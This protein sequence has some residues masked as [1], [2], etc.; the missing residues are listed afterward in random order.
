MTTTTNSPSEVPLRLDGLTCR[1]GGR[2]VLDRVSMTVPAGSVL[3]LLGKNGTGKTTLLGCALG[4]VRPDAGSALV[5]GEPAAGL[6]A[7]AKARLG[8]VP[9]EVA[10]YPWMTAGQM[11][12]YT[13]AFYPRWSGPLVRR[14]LADWDVRPSDRI[15]RMSL[16]TRQKLAIIQQLAHEPDLLVLD[17]PAASLD[18]AARRA[19]LRAVLE[20]TADG[21][22]TV[23]FSTHIMSDLERVADR[24]A[25]LGGGRVLFDGE[26][27]V[28]KDS[29][30]RLHVHAAGPLGPDFTVPGAVRTRVSGQDA[31]VS[32][33]GTTEADLAAVRQR[34][35]ADVRVEDLNL[36]EIFLEVQHEP[37]RP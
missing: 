29:V 23:V 9:Q 15:G 35:G 24:V 3:G 22:R 21:N 6:S 10:L 8:F 32:V 7:G 19:F 33:R 36:E 5:L 37:A 2:A 20:V 26:L 16:G 34:Y 13:S 4:L 11:L 17:E 28:L 27:D 31:L 12:E 1:R 25:I 30:K 18:P 14:L